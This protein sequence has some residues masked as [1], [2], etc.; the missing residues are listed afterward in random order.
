[1]YHPQGA[2]VG[3]TN[4]ASDYEFIELKNAGMAAVNLSRYSITGGVSFLFPDLTLA[5]GAR[6]VV[7]ANATAFRARYPDPTVVVAG[8]YVGSLNNGG[9]SLHLF[10][11]QYEP[12]QDC[13]YDSKWYPATD[14][15]G[16]SLVALNE[17]APGTSTGTKAGW[18]VGAAVDG[19]PGKPEGAAPTFP[20]VVVNEVLNHSLAPAVD[21]LELRNTGT[22]PA[23][24]ARG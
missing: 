3:S 1:M 11:S 10:G 24:I 12:I 17:D 8:E 15:S 4:T 18:R 7:V 16:F 14:G 23:D 2:L 6:A 20:T 19:T 13:S 21:M 22:T 5:P 9:D